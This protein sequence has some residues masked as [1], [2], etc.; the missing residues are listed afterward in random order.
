MILP[1]RY[2]NG[3]A[4]RDGQPLYPE[5]WKGC[6]GAWN[7]GLGVTGL[8]LRDQSGF[9]RHGT[10]TNGPT[11]GVSGK[12]QV[13]T[14]VAA[15]SQTIEMGTIDA[16]KSIPKFTMAGWFQRSSLLS[17]CTF[18][19]RTGANDYCDIAFWND[20]NLYCEIAPSYIAI[21]NNT[22]NLTHVAMVL[23]NATLSVWVNGIKSTLAPASTPPATTPATNSLKV[24]FMPFVNIYDNGSVTDL[25]I[26]SRA[27]KDS[28]IRLLATRRGIAYEMAPRRRSQAQVTTNRRRRIIIGGNR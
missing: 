6:V 25:S 17:N 11:W 22:R 27:L 19:L 9:G 18:T 4:P 16:V 13:I 7:P 3:F 2:A 21:P 12:D 23:D 1:G 26:Y 14:C 20:G 8:T 10:L 5:L 28:Q 15:S 24:G